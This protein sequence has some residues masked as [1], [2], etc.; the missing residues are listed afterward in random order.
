MVTA[1]LAPSRG[2]TALH[3]PA[4]SGFGPVTGHPVTSRSARADSKYRWPTWLRPS[5]IRSPSHPCSAQATRIPAEHSDRAD[6]DPSVQS[7]H[8]TLTTTTPQGPGYIPPARVH[9]PADK[10]NRPNVPRCGPS[11]QQKEF[12]T[13]T[14]YSSHVRRH[15]LLTVPY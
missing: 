12:I 10:P 14:T 8:M 15:K 7:R 9:I 3:R 13:A 4:P 5:R 2:Q 11:R 6:S 1:A